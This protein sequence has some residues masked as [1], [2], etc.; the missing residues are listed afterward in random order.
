MLIEFSLRGRESSGKL[1]VKHTFE[2]LPAHPVAELDYPSCEAFTYLRKCLNRPRGDVISL[3]NGM[4]RHFI[5]QVAQLECDI[6]A[7]INASHSDFLGCI[8][9]Q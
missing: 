5:A 6:A 9:R 3:C 2:H 7:A 8:F 4:N 1:T